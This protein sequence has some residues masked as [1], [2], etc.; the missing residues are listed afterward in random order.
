MGMASNSPLFSDVATEYME[1]KRLS[2]RASTYFVQ[3]NMLKHIVA[4]LGK[5]KIKDIRGYHCQNSVNRWAGRLPGSV[6]SVKILANQIFEYAIR[7]G[8][9]RDNPMDGVILPKKAEKKREDNYYTKQE[10]SMFLT[11]IQKN[12][13]SYYPLF[14]LLAYSGMRIGELLALTWDD[15]D[16]EASTISI[17]KTLSRSKLEGDTIITKPKTKTGVRMIL[18]DDVT[19]QALASHKQE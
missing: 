12:K 3:T 2:L 6:S 8:Y 19:T 7:N 14:R 16:L 1:V 11:F 10:L 18:I 5:L 13:P 9:I 15:I 17:N 4:S